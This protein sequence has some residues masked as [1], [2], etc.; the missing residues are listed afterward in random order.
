RVIDEEYRAIKPQLARFLPGLKGKKAAIFLGATRMTDLVKTFD[1]LGM[2]VVFTGSRFGDAVNYRDAW[3][4]IKAGACIVDNPSECDVETLLYELKPDVFIGG[5]KEQ[6][7]SHKFGIGLCLPQMGAYVGFR[8]FTNFARSVYKAV[9]A[10]VWR[11][12]RG[13]IT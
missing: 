10:P 1:D 6:S 5:I 8:G 9:Y 2:E 13:E 12:A 4:M 11:F 7:L 3:Q